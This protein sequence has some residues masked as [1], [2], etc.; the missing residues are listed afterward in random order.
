MINSG[1]EIIDIGG[2]STRPGSKTISPKK[3]GKELKIVKNFK[4][5][6]PKVKLSVDTRKSEVMENSIKI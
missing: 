4:K 2:E 5:K 3:D 1:A 6:F